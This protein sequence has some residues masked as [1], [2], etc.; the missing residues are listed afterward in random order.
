MCFGSRIALIWLALMRFRIYLNNLCQHFPAESEMGVGIRLKES[1]W[2]CEIEIECSKLVNVYICLCF[3]GRIL[4]ISSCKR[5]NSAEKMR[6]YVYI[7]LLTNQR[8]CSMVQS[9]DGNVCKERH[10]NSSVVSNSSHIFNCVY[11]LSENAQAQIRL[12]NS[13]MKMCDG[14]DLSGCSSTIWIFDI[15]FFPCGA[16]YFIFLTVC[17]Q[18]ER[19]VDENLSWVLINYSSSMLAP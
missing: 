10:F 19:E 14:V 9:I 7:A 18:R 17:R 16:Y 8:I 1:D 11:V 4:Y 6:I 5:I 13:N 2:N 12:S 3:W 15:Y